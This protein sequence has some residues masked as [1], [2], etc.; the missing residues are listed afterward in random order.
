MPCFSGLVC[1]SSFHFV[2]SYFVLCVVFHVVLTGSHAS[3]IFLLFNMMELETGSVLIVD[4]S[5]AGFL[6]FSS[7]ALVVSISVFLFLVLF[8][9]VVLVFSSSSFSSFPP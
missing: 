4:V 5:L 3:A 1:L 2:L 6:F 9:F 8:V 7:F